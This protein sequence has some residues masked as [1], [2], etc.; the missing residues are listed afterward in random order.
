MTESSPSITGVAQ[1]A[2]SV[3]D[4]DAAVAFYRDVLGLPFLFAAPPA[5][6]FL[7]CGPTRL[8]LSVQPEG[9][10]A[11]HPIVYYAPD[12]IR[13]AVE[14]IRAKGATIKEEPKA[15]ARLGNRVVWLA[16]TEDPDGHLVGLMTEVLV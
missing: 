15:I 3:K 14:A 5:L 4:L 8:M 13:A 9:E 12:D 2:I 11:S 1:L 10:T 16:F 7:Q 6:A